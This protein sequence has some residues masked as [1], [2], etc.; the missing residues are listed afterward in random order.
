MSN[1]NVNSRCQLENEGQAAYDS[2]HDPRSASGN[3]S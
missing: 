2:D 3:F 1:D